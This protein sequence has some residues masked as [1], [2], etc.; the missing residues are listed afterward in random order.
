MLWQALAW[1][2][3]QHSL[4]ASGGGTADRHIHF[5]NC[6]TGACLTSV[7]TNSQVHHLRSFCFI[8]WVVMSCVALLYV[9]S[10]HVLFFHHIV[11]Q[12]RY[13]RAYIMLNDCFYCRLSLVVLVL[14]SDLMLLLHDIDVLHTLMIVSTHCLPVFSCKSTALP[15]LTSAF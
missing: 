4:L 8:F 14:L 5:W 13:R 6:N 9:T 12:C 15:A 2:P 1:C 3:W 11:H 10:Y 7:D